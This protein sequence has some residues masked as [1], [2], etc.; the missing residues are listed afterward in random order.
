MF[1]DLSGRVIACEHEA[2]RLTSTDIGNGVRR[3]V[4]GTTD[5]NGKPLTSPND[6]VVSS[7]G[8]IWFTDPDCEK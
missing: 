1:L 5:F 3:V 2:R 7:D 6:C 4:D 8:A